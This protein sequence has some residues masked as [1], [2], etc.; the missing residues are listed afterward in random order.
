M[1]YWMLLH[2]IALA[3]DSKAEAWSSGRDAAKAKALSSGRDALLDREQNA[4][5]NCYETRVSSVSADTVPVQWL[6]TFQKV[7]ATCCHRMMF[8][9]LL[10]Y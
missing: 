8:L 6:N 5:R 9:C 1:T 7:L 4:G 10:L 2:R 3:W